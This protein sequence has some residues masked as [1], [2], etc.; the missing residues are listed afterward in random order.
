[1]QKKAITSTQARVVSPILIQLVI[2]KRVMISED[3]DSA[4]HDNPLRANMVEVTV[5]LARM[6]NNFY[7]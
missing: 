5:T 2:L 1:M 4:T 7:R 6:L 3:P